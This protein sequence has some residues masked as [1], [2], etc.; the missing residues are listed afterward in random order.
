MFDAEL[1]S[2]KREIDLR[3]YAAGQGYVLAPKESWRGSA[4]MRNA[5]GD[6]V[7]IKRNQNGHYVYFSVHDDR[8]NGTIVDFVQ[9]RDKCSLGIVRKQL[10]P[11]LGRPPV[12]VPEFSAC[13][14]PRARI[15]CA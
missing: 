14:Q 9:V 3:A 6:K 15:A 13:I 8:D 11:W 10:R 7:I 1:E 2:F 5:S 4:V 12:P